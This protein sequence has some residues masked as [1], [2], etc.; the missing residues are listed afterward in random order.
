[1]S[2]R[3]KKKITKKSTKNTKNTEPDFSAFTMSTELEEYFNKI[4]DDAFKKFNDYT[5]AC[6]CSSNSD[7]DRDTMI[8]AIE[9][10]KKFESYNKPGI[11]EICFTSE[12]ENPVKILEKYLCLPRKDK[13]TYLK[14]FKENNNPY[15]FKPDINYFCG[16]TVY[17]DDKRYYKYIME[18]T[19]NYVCEL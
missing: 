1:M 18:A 17:D 8:E 16:V 13:S 11:Q 9:K 6:T 5:K 3:G 2:S 7:L 14:A 12:I 10:L 19:E 4:Y 15:T